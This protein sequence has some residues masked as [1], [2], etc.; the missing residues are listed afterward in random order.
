MLHYGSSGFA[1]VHI[2]FI[3]E[4]LHNFMIKE[5]NKGG[6]KIWDGNMKI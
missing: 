2:M 6:M 4:Q 5:K 3:L 1:K